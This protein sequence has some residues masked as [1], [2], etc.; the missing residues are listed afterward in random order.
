MLELYQFEECPYCV[1][2]RIKLSELGL[3]YISRTAPKGS[4]KRKYL[5][6]LG[7]KQ[8]VPFLVDQDKGVMMYESDDIIEYLQKTY[9]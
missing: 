8:Q 3:D 5:E 7:G 6:K 2:V 4:A 9:E 1:K